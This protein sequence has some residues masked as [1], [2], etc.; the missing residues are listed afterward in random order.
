MSNINQ[1]WEENVKVAW[2]D[3]R[4]RKIMGHKGGMAGEAVETDEVKGSG[5]V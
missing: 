4:E 3:R 5:V 2:E 1:G